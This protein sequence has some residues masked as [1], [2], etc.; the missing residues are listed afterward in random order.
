[1]SEADAAVYGLTADGLLAARIGDFGCIAV[2][3]DG[4][5]RLAIARC[6][7]KPVA[8]WTV[9]DAL[10]SEGIVADETAFRAHVEDIAHHRRQLRRLARAHVA[11]S[12]L[13]PWGTAQ[14]ETVY[15]EGVI[16]VSTAS[17]G[18]FHL[19]EKRLAGLD[20]LLHVDG[21]W[22]EEDVEWAKVA[23]AFPD[24]FTDRENAAAD[25]T[26]RAWFPL[27]WQALGGRHDR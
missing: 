15:G 2:P 8:E 22:Y 20:P 10:A 25:R 14:Q 1:M 26:L 5:L 17:H 4:G 6:T 11:T 18:G 3:G 27:I 9:S 24:L 19:S 16:F 21:G 12:R 23:L 13:T 7:G